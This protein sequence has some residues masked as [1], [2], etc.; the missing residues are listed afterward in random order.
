MRNMTSPTHRMTL[1][2]DVQRISTFIPPNLPAVAGHDYGLVNEEVGA[3]RIGAAQ[4]FLEKVIENYRKN[5]CREYLVGEDM[6]W[7]E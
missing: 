2:L 3:D 7:E 4:R 6:V 5:I 1:L